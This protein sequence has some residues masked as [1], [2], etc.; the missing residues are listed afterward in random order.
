MNKRPKSREETPK[1]GSDSARATAP[2]QYATALHKKQGLLNHF[3]CKIREVMA[4][5][6]NDQILYN[7]ISSLV[8][9]CFGRQIQAAASGQLSIS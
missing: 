7:I 5:T 1:E 6:C 8:W 2:Q 4:I 9:N 3:R